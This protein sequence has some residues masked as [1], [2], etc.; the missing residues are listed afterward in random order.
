MIICWFDGYM[1][2]ISIFTYFSVDYDPLLS[3][4]APLEPSRARPCC[5]RHGPLAPDLLYH[6]ASAIDGLA[7]FDVILACQGKGNL[8]FGELI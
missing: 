7:I 2:C 6:E 5:C 3:K 4:A 8:G 1:Q